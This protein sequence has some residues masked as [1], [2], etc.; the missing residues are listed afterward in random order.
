MSG[1]ATGL[2]GYIYQQD[3]LAYRV[4]ASVVART[5]D[6]SA[7]QSLQSFKI[8]GGVSESG[9]SWDLALSNNP[10]SI[11]LLECKDTEITKGDRAI[12]YKRVRRVVASG[13]DAETI[14]VGWVTDRGKQGNILTH[15]VGMTGLVDG[16]HTIP[17]SAPTSVVSAATALGEAIYFLCHPDPFGGEEE[18]YDPVP[19]ASAKSL[20]RRLRVDP[21]SAPSL[22]DTVMHLVDKVFQAGTAESLIQYIRGHLTSEIRDKGVAS[23]TL[24]GFLEE[25]GTL[26]V[27]VSVEGSLKRFLQMYSASAQ[28][29]PSAGSIV[30]AR[31]PN[32]PR[33]E[34]T[35]AERAPNYSTQDSHVVVAPQGIGKTVLSQQAFV[36]VAKSWNKHRVL[37]VEAALLEEAET[38]DLVSVCTVLSG[39]GPTWLS[40][41]GLDA[42]ERSRSGIWQTTIDRLLANPRL[43]LLMTAREEVLE[44]GEWL[45]RLTTSL[46]SVLLKPLSVD[47]VRKA[48]QDAGLNP[49]QNESLLKVLRIPFLLS[50]YA[51]IATPSELPLEASGEVTA[52]QVVEK[53]WSMRVCAPS[54]GHRL[55]GEPD[56]SFAAKRAAAKYLA[57]RT[58]EGLLAIERPDRDLLVQKGI[59]MLLHE[60]VLVAQG[61]YSV[62]WFHDWLLEYSLVDLIISDIESIGPVGLA[63]RVIRLADHEHRQDYVVRTAAVGGA[64]RAVANSAQ[65]GPVET[66]LTM[67]YDRFPGAASDAVAVLIEGSES[68]LELARLPQQLLLEAIHLAIGLRAWQWATQISDLPRQVFSGELGPQLHRVVTE[69][70]LEVMQ[71]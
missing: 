52:F 13:V 21:W 61:T 14:Q 2:G 38:R 17:E 39:L 71:T 50:L 7:L 42:I 25:V 11:E 3:Y 29:I 26:S 31:L 40:I 1:G 6:G 4:L 57:E 18:K 16:I 37:R 33:K 12:F 55:V 48:F 46:P 68:G 69:F 51:R 56:E 63:E 44:A 5:L 22:R 65:W 8:E 54:I 15:L 28:H 30:W 32:S 36:H 66:Y 67:M 34:W 24:D 47:E 70:E 9:P 60:G 10:G 43:T 27:M 49:P 45:Q 35:I 59:Q 58:R 53:F 20:L 64:K 19:L 23:N 62:R 41:D